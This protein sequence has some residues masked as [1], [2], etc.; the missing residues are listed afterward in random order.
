MASRYDI[1][2]SNPHR[3]FYIPDGIR[4][5]GIM[6]VAECQKLYLKAINT[7]QYYYIYKGFNLFPSLSNLQFE[8]NFPLD[9]KLIWTPQRGKIRHPKGEK[10]SFTFFVSVA[11]VVLQRKN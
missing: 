4:T 9:N 11:R 6:T 5:V 10:K 8:F 3:L 2:F 1:Y 7:G